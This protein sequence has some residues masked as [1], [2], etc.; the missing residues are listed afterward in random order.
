VWHFQTPGANET[1]LNEADNQ[2]YTWNGT[3]WVKVGTVGNSAKLNDEIHGATEKKTATKAAVEDNDEFAITDATETPAYALKKLTWANLKAGILA[4]FYAAPNNTPVNENDRFVI[5]GQ[6]GAQGLYYNTFKE[7]K[8]WIFSNLPD[9]VHGLTNLPG[10]AGELNGNGELFVR[11]SDNNTYKTKVSDI[12]N[13]VLAGGSAPYRRRKNGQALGE[14]GSVFDISDFGGTPSIIRYRGW[15]A[16]SGADNARP[17]LVMKTSGGGAS[18]IDMQ[19][20]FPFRRV[21]SN[22]GSA[23]SADSDYANGYSNRLYLIDPVDAN[24]TVKGNNNSYFDISVF[25][26]SGYTFI[27]W[28]IKYHSG[29]GGM[30]FASGFASG[31]ISGNITHVG[32]KWDTQGTGAYR[33]TLGDIDITVE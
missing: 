3:T 25:D 13:F 19:A 5:A 31:S 20:T 1:H 22:W 16:A 17:S 24:Y 6:L 33:D 30:I 26:Q 21:I 7:I 15:C 18:Y 10:P 29:S 9:W 2:M 4:W 32:I 12:K 27:E 14:D 23:G 11:G 28:T 8:D